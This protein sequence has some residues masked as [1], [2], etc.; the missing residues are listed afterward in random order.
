MSEN[1][2]Q[3]TE[4]AKVRMLKGAFDVTYDDPPEKGIVCVEVDINTIKVDADVIG[5]DTVDVTVSLCDAEGT[6]LLYIS[7]R[8]PTGCSL[9]IMMEKMPE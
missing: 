1:E 5:S 8:L 3:L 6:P 4:I 9:N 2:L 7:H